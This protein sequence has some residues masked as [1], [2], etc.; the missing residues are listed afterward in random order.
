MTDHTQPPLPFD[1]PA[2]VGHHHPPTSF[3]AAARIAPLVSKQ[4]R[5]ILALI[6]DAPHTDDELWELSGLN[7]NSSR[8]ARVWLARHGLVADSGQVRRN[9]SGNEC[10]LW[11]ITTRGRAAM[12]Q[13]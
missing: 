3:A 7:V 5:L 10:I 4:R 8:P 13:Q 1:E 2:I 12:A 9:L 11:E 6:A